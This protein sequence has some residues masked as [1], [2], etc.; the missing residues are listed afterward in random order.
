MLLLDHGPIERA[1]AGADIFNTTGSE[2]VVDTCRP[3]GFSEHLL[4]GARWKNPFMQRNASGTEGVFAILIG[5]GAIAVK[6]DGEAMDSQLGHNRSGISNCP[7]GSEIGLV[8]A[9][10]AGVRIMVEGRRVFCS[11]FRRIT[12][13]GRLQLRAFCGSAPCRADRDRDRLPA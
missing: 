2:I 5:A 13:R 3:A 7:A 10:N 4:E 12:P 1:T 11:G 9:R 6:G 8:R